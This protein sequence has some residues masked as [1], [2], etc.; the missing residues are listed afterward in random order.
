MGAVMVVR[1][2]HGMR[3]PHPLMVDVRR[4]RAEQ[5]QGW[6]TAVT[7]PPKT[8]SAVQRGIAASAQG[9]RTVMAEVLLALMDVTSAQLDRA[10]R[11]EM[12]R[13]AEALRQDA[14]VLAA[15]SD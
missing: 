3:L 10:S 4:Q 7:L 5:A 9:D 6:L 11:A 13:L 15:G 2:A 14:A 8:R 12:Q 1:L